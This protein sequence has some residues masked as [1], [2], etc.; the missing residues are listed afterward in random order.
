MA[1]LAIK[2]LLGE[3]LRLFVSAGGV[4]A[5]LF[6]VLLLEGVFAGTS[7]Q[8]VAY[9]ENT[10]ADVWVMQDGVSNMHMSTSALPE[11][12]GA[13][14][15][16]VPG[17]ESVT[18]I[19][20]LSSVVRV[21]GSDSFS[22]IVGLPQGAERGGPWAMAAGSAHPDL[23][24][25]IVPE[26]LARKRGIGL[27]DTVTILGRPFTVAGTSR[28]TFSLANSVTFISYGDMQALLGSPGV[29][30]YFLAKA[31]PGVGAEEMA[32]R[33]RDTVP[34][35]NVLTRDAFA[36]NDRAMARQMGVDLIGIMSL[37]GLG[38]GVLIIGLTVYTATVR[39]AGEYGIAKALGAR[40]W[41]L[42]MVVGMETGLLALL[43][44]AMALALAL[45]VK[46]LVQALA[47]EIPLA[48]PVASLARIA[49]IAGGIAVVA[50]ALPAYRI[51]RV[52]PAVVFK[53]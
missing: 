29:A 21:R 23:G 11:M 51:S 37:V 27:G 49:V 7:E 16:A 10:D 8:L 42:F 9:L 18:P 12:A 44:L 19:L 25:A 4:A 43:S 14:V 39:R 13:R 26:T 22:Y 53:G 31:Q 48:Y 33:I 6:L 2:N 28:G 24:E 36:D 50:A 34:G 15:A 5:A 45:L 47:P 46:P 40:G 3:R 20:Y 32:Q 30:S 52:E 41:Q 38:A 1:R 35:V 17:V